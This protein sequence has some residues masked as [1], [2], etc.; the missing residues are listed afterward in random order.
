MHDIAWRE[1]FE[2]GHQTI[3]FEHKAFVSLINQVQHLTQDK[4]P[5]ERLLRALEEVIKYAEFHFF[6]E[7][8]VMADAAYPGLDKHRAHHQALLARLREEATRFRRGEDN[9]Q[10]A[11]TFLVMWFAEHT[12]NEDLD[13]AAAVKRRNLKDF[14]TEIIGR[15]DPDGAA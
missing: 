7:E 14:Y 3:D 5:D 10:E 8:N 13:I 4:A 9:M 6:S 12:V 1:W 15:E 2:I 11:I